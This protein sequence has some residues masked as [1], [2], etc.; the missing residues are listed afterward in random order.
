MAAFS[1][2]AAAI[3]RA[4]AKYSLL[5]S[6]FVSLF[7]LPEAWVTVRQFR[8]VPLSYLTNHCSLDWDHGIDHLLYLQ[9][10]IDED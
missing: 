7:G 5:E 6:E 3:A 10:L 2:S 4:P 1:P 8:F 9:G